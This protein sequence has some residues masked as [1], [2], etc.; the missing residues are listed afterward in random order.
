MNL[1]FRI[2]LTLS[3]LSLFIA[4]FLINRK[5]VILPFHE[6]YIY[7]FSYVL[8]VAFPFLF[9]AISIRL[10]KGLGKDNLGTIQ[11]VETANNDFLSNY[12]AFFFVALSINS[13][14]LFAVCFILTALF[15]FV[16][17]VSYFN[18]ILLLFRYNFYYVHLG[19]R[20]KVMLITRR[21]IKSPE[22]INK[23]EQYGRINDYTFI[24]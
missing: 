3:A 18:P 20:S 21:K 8:Y 17:R 12:L 16:S 6:W 14:T 7:A 1:I 23:D 5:T 2:F 19:N 22:D 9:S 15:T 4:V 11:F 13:W 24:G 10:S